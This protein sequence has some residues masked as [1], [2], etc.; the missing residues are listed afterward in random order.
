M[1]NL[2]QLVSHLIA[3]APIGQYFSSGTK[4]DEAGFY[5][6]IWPLFAE[7]LY[8]AVG[9][10][11]PLDAG[12]VEVSYRYKKAMR[13]ISSPDLEPISFLLRN[14]LPALEDGPTLRG[15]F[16]QL[17]TERG[18]SRSALTTET[19]GKDSGTGAVI[20][21][22]SVIGRKNISYKTKE[23]AGRI[24]SLFL[25]CDHSDHFVAEASPGLHFVVVDGDW[26]VESKIN[27]LEAGF[28]GVFEIAQLATLTDTLETTSHQARGTE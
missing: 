13:I 4:F 27:L 17:S 6:A 25:R 16:N 8:E 2:G 22:Q 5:K 9:T 14:G 18:W 11:E 19:T 23:L 12:A 7:C 20:Q 28:S 26:P 10:R 1:N 3:G 21:S 15:A 24:R